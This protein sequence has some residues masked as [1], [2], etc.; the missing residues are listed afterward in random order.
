MQGAQG[1]KGIT[2]PPGL[3]GPVGDQG[4]PGSQGAPGVRGALGPAG[5]TGPLMNTVDMLRSSIHSALQA[6]LD[7]PDCGARLDSSARPETRA[8]GTLAECFGARARRS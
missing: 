7:R 1:L 4:V 8:C 5:P 3:P 2:G 6:L